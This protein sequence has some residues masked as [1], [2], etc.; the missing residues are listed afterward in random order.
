MRG[1]QQLS[2]KDPL[3]DPNAPHDLYIPRLRFKLRANPTLFKNVPMH[4]ITADLPDQLFE[5][6]EVS[7]SVC[8]EIATDSLEHRVEITGIDTDDLHQRVIAAAKAI[9]AEIGRHD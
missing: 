8:R 2:I 9:K 6:H 1:E 4:D 5:V 7:A 3:L